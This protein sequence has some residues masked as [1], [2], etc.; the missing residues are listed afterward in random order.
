VLGE[1]PFLNLESL[2][3]I[4]GA[5]LSSGV[6][7][8]DA[9]HFT[10]HPRTVQLRRELAERIGPLE[11]VSTAFFFPSADRSNI[12][13]QPSKEPTG[14]IGDMAWYCMRALAEFA[15]ADAVFVGAHGFARKDAVTGGFL[16]GSGV[17]RLSDGCTS[18][19][20]AG[21]TVG[22]CLMDLQ[23]MGQRGVISMDDFVLDWVGGFLIPEKDFE[24]GFTQKSG[25]AGPSAFVRVPTPSVRRQSVQMME[26]FAALAADPCGPGVAASIALSERTQGL[27]DA[28]FAGLEVVG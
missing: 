1:K 11:S 17:V 10:H 4:T 6:A 21:Y 8:M 7:F 5:C 12:R 2:R 16:R 24:V 3:R 22:S 15:P 23:L 20:D 28:V 26:D 13:L 25:L 18:T 14:A 9:T 19:W 27:V